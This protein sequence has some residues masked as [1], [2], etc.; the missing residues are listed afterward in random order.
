MTLR[1]PRSESH[2]RL[3]GFRSPWMKSFV[4]RAFKPLEIERD[5]ELSMNEVKGK[6]RKVYFTTWPI[7]T[8]F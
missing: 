8:G 2:M 1:T 7:T 3:V 6:R 4:C 5:R